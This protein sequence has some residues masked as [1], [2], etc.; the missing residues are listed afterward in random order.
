VARVHCHRGLITWTV[1]S[2]LL[3]IN[4]T[5]CGL[6]L[7]SFC[8]HPS[9]TNSIDAGVDSTPTNILLFL[10]QGEQYPCQGP[11]KSEWVVLW[12][13]LTQG[14]RNHRLGFYRHCKC[15][16]PCQQKT[17]ADSVRL[18]MDAGTSEVSFASSRRQFSQIP[19][20]WETSLHLRSPQKPHALPAEKC[21][22]GKH[23]QAAWPR[24][25][26]GSRPS[27]VLYAISSSRIYIH[28]QCRKI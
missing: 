11:E 4:S 5:V 14:T 8:A 1:D 21:Q 19:I 18:K 12:G 22:P 6:H 3:F 10:D 17:S 13:S 28:L 9:V 23:R 25:R 24:P 16:Q 20:N 15:S 2:G 26:R 27:Y 7:G